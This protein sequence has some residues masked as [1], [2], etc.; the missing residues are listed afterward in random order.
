MEITL[1]ALYDVHMDNGG[2]FVATADRFEKDGNVVVLV[3]TRDP[4]RD[5]F[6]S[7]YALGSAHW[8]ASLKPL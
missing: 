6:P 5:V 1:G 8:A 2:R 7:G 4:V 3:P